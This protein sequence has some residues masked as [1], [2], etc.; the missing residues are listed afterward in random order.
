MLLFPPPSLPPS[1]HTLPAW[2]DPATFSTFVS[3]RKSYTPMHACPCPFDFPASHSCLVCLAPPF[4]FSTIYLLP[5]LILTLTSPNFC[6]HQVGRVQVVDGQGQLVVRF[7]NA[8]ATHPAHI[9]TPGFSQ[10]LRS[11]KTT[12]TEEICASEKRLA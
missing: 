1:I 12:Q 5:R 7:G 3:C 6:T 4:L 10:S 11:H 9:L 8:P 2:V